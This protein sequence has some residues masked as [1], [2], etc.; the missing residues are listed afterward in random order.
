MENFSGDS[1]ITE[2][3]HSFFGNFHAAINLPIDTLH[4]LCPVYFHSEVMMKA[5]SSESTFRS[6][7]I[8]VSDQLCEQM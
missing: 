6:V 8:T 2:L 3:I 7:I 5:I 4:G 1:V